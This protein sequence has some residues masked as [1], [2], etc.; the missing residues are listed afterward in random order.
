MYNQVKTICL[1]CF[2]ADR[3]I[4]QSNIELLR[5]FAALGVVIL[6]YNNTSLGG[7]FAFVDPTSVNQL[8][9][10]VFE[11]VF[12]CVVNIYV[13]ISGYF[14]KNTTKIDLLK[15][16]K[17]F[18]MYLV[19][20]LLAY[21]IKELPKGELFDFKIFLGYF[22]PSYWFVY[23]YIALYLISPF[24]SL[25][26]KHMG[27][28]GKTSLLIVLIALFSVYPFAWDVISNTTKYSFWPAPSANGLMQGIST[29]S[30]FGAD[31]GYTL[32][33]FIL[34]FIIG[35]YIRDK[36][37]DGKKA[38][39]S[40]ML[41]LLLINTELIVAWTYADY[42]I[43]GYPLP[44]TICWSYENPL[45]ILEAVL[46]F[47]FFSNL[48]MK[49][50]KVINTLATAAFPTYL[51]HINLLPYLQIAKYVESG[52]V[53]MTLHML[54]SMAALFL[55]SFVIYKAYELLTN[56]LFNAISKRWLRRRYI[57]AGKDI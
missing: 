49:D 42:F 32:V 27:K 10:V 24:I 14:M 3:T 35:C 40:I 44:S 51:I 36:V 41:I 15:P 25:M 7:G 6:H 21:L 39:P 5:I 30:L 34:M 53:I 1:R 2:M 26:L 20:E 22:T 50:N 52:P 4:R 17:L 29:V 12:M 45:I 28:K 47:L 18:S 46:F 33:N 43:T 57:I 23:V 56:P 9:M 11:S 13:L 16:V 8:I 54:F 31:R 48:K 37:E 55:I 38:K 19:F